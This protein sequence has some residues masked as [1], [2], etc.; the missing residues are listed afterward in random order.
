MGE[1]KT[2]EQDDGKKWLFNCHG[3]LRALVWEDWGKVLGCV[4][5]LVDK[6]NHSQAKAHNVSQSWSLLW[7]LVWSSHT[8]FCRCFF[9]LVNIGRQSGL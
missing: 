7:G 8:G 3:F 9:V 4:I 6:P 2:D 1:V 5:D